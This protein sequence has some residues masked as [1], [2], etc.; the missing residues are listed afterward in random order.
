MEEQTNINNSVRSS[1]TIS[2]ITEGAETLIS[3][4]IPKPT[5]PLKK[6]AH[7]YAKLG[8][9]IF[10]VRRDKTPLIPQWQSN[11][12]NDAEQ[13]E[14]WWSENPEASIGVLCGPGSGVSVVDVDVKNNKHGLDQL[15]ALEDAHGNMGS[16]PTSKTPSGGIH[17]FFSAESLPFQ[18]SEGRIAKD[19]DTRTAR[20]DGSSAGYAILPPSRDPLGEPYRWEDDTTLDHLMN[21]PSA[22][23]WLA[24]RAAFKTEDS[25]AIL[26]D[27]KLRRF[28]LSKSRQHWEEAFH[29][30]KQQHPLTEAEPKTSYSLEHPY[31]AKIIEDELATVEN[32]EADQ[33]GQLNRSAFSIATALAGT[34]LAKAGDTI[35]HNSALRTVSSSLFSAA[36]KMHDLDPQERWNSP[37]GRSKA[38]K[39]IESGLLAGVRQ[40]REMKA[41]KVRDP[42]GNAERGQL[43][44]TSMDQVPREKVEYLWDPFIA[45]GKITLL[46]GRPG[47]GK[48]QV[49]L[50]IAARVTTGEPFPSIVLGQA[51]RRDPGSVIL[52]AGEDGSG[53]VIRPRLEAAGADLSK[54]HLVKGVLNTLP[55]GS[56][57]LDMFSLR[58][59]IPEIERLITKLGDVRAI[60]VDPIGSYTG[61]ADTNND[62]SV[63]S[64]LMP[65][66]ALA[67]KHRVAMI[68]VAH[69]NK[70]SGNKGSSDPLDKVM[71]SLAFVGV[72]RAVFAV[73]RDPTEPPDSPKRVFVYVKGNLTGTLGGLELTIKTQWVED[74]KT[75]RIEWGR[76]TDVGAWEAFNQSG[77][78]DRTA[79]QDAENFLLT[80]LAN[81]PMKADE[82]KK[83]AKSDEISWATVRRAQVNLGIKPERQGFGPGSSFLWALPTP[84]DEAVTETPDTP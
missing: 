40:P 50:D 19:I 58:E 20:A 10:P 33:N 14:R 55:D 70:G 4:G 3:E 16:I 6:A 23:E 36:M 31:I 46:V 82:L 57:F 25:D 51:P 29:T 13:I 74:V 27:E 47:E 2:A 44:I 52:I 78:E 66:A 9:R 32:S 34:G 39:T 56:Q 26:S 22:P 65:L 68:L 30:Y 83:L 63:R 5:W 35:N 41:P 60:I 59:R 42:M 80:N 18:K 75:S 62:A 77:G 76:P 28:I 45:V 15:K 81:N 17:L 1:G 11:A 79:L 69:T 48:S 64:V 61:K 37:D 84:E 7:F 49:T 72:A 38:Q 54:V 21:P 71:G 67:G 8:W 43:V 24:I 12:S 73:A 53:D